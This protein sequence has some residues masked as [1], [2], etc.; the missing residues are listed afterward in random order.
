VITYK[1]VTETD[2]R[3][4]PIKDSWYTQ[5][6]KPADLIRSWDY[7]IEAVCAVCSKP[8]VAEHFLAD[9]THFEREQAGTAEV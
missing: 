8:I 1:L 6:G 5:I 4:E 3:I 9:W 2:H 7:P